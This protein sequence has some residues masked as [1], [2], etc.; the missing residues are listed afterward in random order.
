[1]CLDVGALK[2]LVMRLEIRSSHESTGARKSKDLVA[3]AA[4]LV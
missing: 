4:K 2:S 1:M 3:D